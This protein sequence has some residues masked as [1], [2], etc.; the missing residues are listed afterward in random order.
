[1]SSYTNHFGDQSGAYLQFRPNYPDALFYFL[2]GLC[3]Q[4]VLAWDCG[5]G[6]GQAAVQ[7]AKFFT[8]VVATDLQ[9]AQLAVALHKPNVEYVCCRA[10]ASPFTDG[11]VDI[12]TVAQAL[13]WFTFD[14]FYHEVERVLKPDGI[15]AAWAYSLGEINEPI[16]CI[17]RKL[18]DDIL[19]DTY[20]PK[21]RRY[22]DEHYQTIPFPFKRITAPSFHIEKK[23]DLAQFAGYLNTWSAVKEFQQQNQRNPLDEI[24]RELRAAWGDESRTYTMCWPIHLIV[25]QNTRK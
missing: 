14:A 4:H 5:T 22:I 7:L 1:M 24:I 12:V 10:E 6:N 25:G 11:T 15:I 20:W 18:Y 2:S 8:Q 16:D 23:M 3:S 9:Q 13:H 21:E 19:G 17:L